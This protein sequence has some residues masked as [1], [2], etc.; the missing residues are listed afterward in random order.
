MKKI[1]A[2]FLVLTTINTPV[3]ASYIDK[4]LKEM[5]KTPRY[6]T[7][8]THKKITKRNLACLKKQA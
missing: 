8:Q 3:Y 2:I 4:Q 6:N 5:Q 1:L 7:V